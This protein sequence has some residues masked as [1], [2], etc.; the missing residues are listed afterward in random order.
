MIR[1][2]ISE[3]VL[4]VWHPFDPICPY[5][6]SFPWKNNFDQQSLDVLLEW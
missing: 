4:N 3:V 5:E 2:K 1:R 6:C